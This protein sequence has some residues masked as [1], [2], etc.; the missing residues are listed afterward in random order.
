M[1]FES[2]V[3]RPTYFSLNQV[4][5]EDYN[6]GQLYNKNKEFLTSLQEKLFDEYDV[7]RIYI[8]NEFFEKYSFINKIP[9]LFEVDKFTF[10]EMQD[11]KFNLL[12]NDNIEYYIKTENLIYLYSKGILT[13][14]NVKI[15]KLWKIE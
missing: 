9:I 12:N 4:L 2:T 11:E 5:K 3:D 8:I 1:N 13:E 14:E 6:R 7:E 15:K 10:E